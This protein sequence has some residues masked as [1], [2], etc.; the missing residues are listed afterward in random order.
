MQD[1]NIMKSVHTSHW[2]GIYL[3]SA[4]HRLDW[5]TIF[6]EQR[7]G[8]L[9]ETKRMTWNDSR[10]EIPFPSQSNRYRQE[11]NYRLWN[12]LWTSWQLFTHTPYSPW[13]SNTKWHKY[14][15]TTHL[16]SNGYLL[17]YTNTTGGG[18]RRCMMKSYSQVRNTFLNLRGINEFNVL[19]SPASFWLKYLYLVIKSF[20]TKLY[21]RANNMKLDTFKT[22]LSSRNPD[23]L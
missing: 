8:H 19:P 3:Y 2:N 12:R 4:P 20:Q 7:K 16:T 11:S 15:N 22:R 9:R 21:N 14:K 10:R 5:I 17:I 23:P 18:G 1:K 6:K 13:K